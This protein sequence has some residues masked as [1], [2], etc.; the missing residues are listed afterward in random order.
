M[1]STANALLV[2]GT[3]AAVGKTMVIC[4]LAAYWQAHQG[5]HSLGIFKPIQTGGGDRDLYQQCF[6]CHQTAHEITPIHFESPHIP[7]I[8]AAEAN[9]PLSIEAIWHAYEHLSQTQDWVLIE[10]IGGLGTPLTPETTVA[11]LAWDWRLPTVLVA[12]VNPGTIAQVVSN[13]ALARQARVHLKGIILNCT[14]PCTP[15][16]I[17][18]WA[19]TALIQTLTRV[20][21]LG[22]IPHV[23][24]PNDLSTLTQIA[25]DLALDRLMPLAV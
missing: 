19:S 23:A 16:A 17:A 24:D 10:A 11:D 14:Q 20:P 6:A 5:K 22:V 25:S 15:E 18:T 1:T 4:A 3:D 12:S 7:P 8:A 21:V 2:S 9:Q 13:V